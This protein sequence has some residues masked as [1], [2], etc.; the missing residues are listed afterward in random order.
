MSTLSFR[1]LGPLNLAECTAIQLTHH[2]YDY[3]FIFPPLPSSESFRIDFAAKGAD[4]APV[5]LSEEAYEVPNK[6]Y[7]I[8]EYGALLQCVCSLRLIL[9]LAMN[10]MGG[11]SDFRCFQGII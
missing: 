8:S 11:P 9:G 2:D 5:A 10:C 7:D 6:Y 1:F 3:E 4:D